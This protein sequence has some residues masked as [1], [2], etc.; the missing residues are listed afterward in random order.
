[1][2]SE[3]HLFDEG[4]IVRFTIKEQGVVLDLT[5]ATK[6]ELLFERKDR[7]TYVRDADIYGDPTEG[8]VYCLSVPTEFTM[9]GAFKG[10][11][12]IEYAS[13]KWHS[14]KVEFE[15]SENIVR[16]SED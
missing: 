8:R 5:D 1:M 3:V 9:K 12:Y 2:T 6:I 7:T 11:V 10:Q 14:S 16:P 15:V 13:G 4:T